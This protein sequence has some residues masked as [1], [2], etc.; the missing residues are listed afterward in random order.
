MKSRIFRVSIASSVVSRSIDKFPVKQTTWSVVRFV[1]VLTWKR[2]QF[3]VRGITQRNHEILLHGAGTV[4]PGECADKVGHSEKHH[5]PG[6]GERA[7]LEH[8]QVELKGNGV[9]EGHDDGVGGRV[10][11]AED[12]AEKGYPEEPL[13]RFHEGIHSLQ[14]VVCVF[15]ATRFGRC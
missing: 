3:G 8:L 1:V 15:F 6:D 12:V 11:G 9:D 14:S 5:E 13:V 10:R 7:A 4:P 2:Q